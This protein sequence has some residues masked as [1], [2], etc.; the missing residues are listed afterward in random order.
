MAGSGIG[1]LSGASDAPKKRD[2]TAASTELVLRGAVAKPSLPHVLKVVGLLCP[3]TAHM[4][5]FR[6]WDR[7]YGAS[8]TR[9]VPRPAI[10]LR[11]SM[12]SQPS[13]A[14]RGA[15]LRPWAHYSLLYYGLPDRRAPPPLEKRPLQI[16]PVGRDGP[17]VLQSLG[18]AL[19]HEYVRRGWR[20]RTRSGLLVEVFYAEK[21][22]SPGDPESASNTQATGTVES[23]AIVEVSSDRLSNADDLFTFMSYLSPSGVVL[24]K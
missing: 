10:R 24:R 20:F 19:I 9:G 23:F 21:L 4:G 15:H 2:G 16:V 3:D 7:V 17:A 18:C 11:R 13:A 1:S 8:D 14:P 12:E 6:E 5:Q 22:S